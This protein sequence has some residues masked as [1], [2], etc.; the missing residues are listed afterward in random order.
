MDVDW[1]TEEVVE[2]DWDVVLV[3]VGV[4]V[5]IVRAGVTSQTRKVVL[6]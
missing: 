6:A 5:E 1:L 3:A 4:M 2:V